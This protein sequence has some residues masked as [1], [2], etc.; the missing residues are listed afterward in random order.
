MKITFLDGKKQGTVLEFSTP[1]VTIGRDPSNMLT[2]NTDG[3]S[4]CHAELRQLPEGGWIVV[5]LNSTNGTKLNGEKIAG[6]APLADGCRIEIVENLMELSELKSAPAQV[7]FNPIVT[8]PLAE[9]PAKPVFDGT[10]VRGEVF[11]SS[12]AKTVPIPESALA[13]EVPPPAEKPKE[14]PAKAKGPENLA[15]DL[16]AFSGSL[17]SRKGKGSSGGFFGSSREGEAGTETSSPEAERR[18]RRSNVIFYTILAS[19]VVLVLSVVLLANSPKKTGG[20]RGGGHVPLVVRYEKEVVSKGNVFR[21]EFYLK[22]RIEESVEEAPAGEKPARGKKAKGKKAAPV[23]RSRRV[24]YANFTID[25]VASRRHY[26]KETPISEETVEEL[27]SRI[28]S[29]GIYASAPNTA[30]RDRDQNR[31]LLIVEGARIFSTGVPGEFAPSEFNTVEEAV[32]AVAES[33]GLKTIA[34]TPEQLL[35]QAEDYFLKA[36]DLYDNRA[37]ISNLRDAIMRY[38]AVVES[39][40]QFSPKPKMW[41]QAKKKLD[42]AVRERDAKMRML[43]AEF[44]RLS[45]MNDF[46]AMRQVFLDQM[47]LAEPESREYARAK[48]RLVIIDQVLR[49]NKRK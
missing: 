18:K 5:D 33:F 45:Q 26:S 23:Q 49:K 11:I 21:F 43:D 48:N 8:P 4:R 47:E 42:D 15:E 40:E 10:P 14:E 13:P 25:D 38:R 37:K 29:S 35:K 32:V 24:Y 17:F 27:R 28:R 36:E 7:I 2:L 16:K 22:S 34:L 31:S 6:E 39:L 12:E 46:A 30:P 19:V 3:V 44:N 1:S 20:A 41:A 9:T